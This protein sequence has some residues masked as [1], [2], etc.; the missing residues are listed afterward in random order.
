MATFKVRYLT[1]KPGK[2]GEL[3]RYFWQPSSALRAAGWPSERV[4]PNHAS[5][6][7]ANQLEAAAIARAQELNE[8]LDATR[9]KAAI[10]GARPAPPISSRTLGDLI[11]LYQASDKFTGLEASTQRGYR[12]CLAKLEQWAADAPVRAID[13]V[14]IQNLKRGLSGTPSYANATVRVL[15]LLLAFGRLQGWLVH[16]PAER[17]GLVNLEASGLIWPR[18]AVDVFVAAADKAGYHSVGTAVLLNEWLAQRQGDILRMPR[19]VIRNGALVLR[20]SKT[21]AG[22][23]LPFAMVPR[24]ATRLEEEMARQR[25]REEAGK[26]AAT[27]IIVSEETGAPYKADNFRHVF[28]RIRAAAAKVQPVFE[29]DY[30]LPGRDMAD[31]G[32]F[33]VRMED[34]TFMHLRHT[35]VTRMAEA[36]C[37]PGLI[38]SV[39]GHAEASVNTIIERYRVRTAQMARLAFQR[40]MDAEAP[41]QPPAAVTVSGGGQ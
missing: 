6:S 10:E 34:L 27:T 39:S 31:P 13:T 29:V 20:Q 17:P 3:P 12:Q 4:P 15:R 32:A 37:D 36:E 41:P 22:V 18:G 33:Q 5:F 38:S 25:A 14:R 21:G 1:S 24:L 11:R 16:N 9:A 30:L 28:A 40:R 23:T 26:P 19:S 8:L 7:D 35:G 2:P